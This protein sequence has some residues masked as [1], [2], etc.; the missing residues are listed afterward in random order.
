MVMSQMKNYDPGRGN[1]WTWKKQRSSL[2]AAVHSHGEVGVGSEAPT[3][4]PHHELNPL[5]TERHKGS[6]LWL[7]TF[8]L[9]ALLPILFLFKEGKISTM[10]ALLSICIFIL[11]LEHKLCHS[12]KGVPTTA[13][14]T[15]R[16]ALPVQQ[17]MV[18]TYFPLFLNLNIWVGAILGSKVRKYKQ[19]LSDKCSPQTYLPSAYFSPFRITTV[20][21]L[22]T[23]TVL[24]YINKYKYSIFFGRASCLVGS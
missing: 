19:L 17:L 16:K 18:F 23:A 6:R 1:R 7:L 4:T 12:R 9:T 24:F 20:L 3:D 15:L 11:S 13:L 2:P 21:V 5:R 22:F 8:S 10:T 14:L